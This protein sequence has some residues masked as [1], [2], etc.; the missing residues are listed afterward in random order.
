VGL[1]WTWR[2]KRMQEGRGLVRQ[3]P[4]NPTMAKVFFKSNCP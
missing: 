3:S 4:A 2:G 1:G